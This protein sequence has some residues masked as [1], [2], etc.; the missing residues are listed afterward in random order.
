MPEGNG[1]DPDQLI[2]N[3]LEELAQFDLNELR[4]PD[5]ILASQSGQYKGVVPSV[6]SVPTGEDKELQWLLQSDFVSDEMALKAV[7]AITER[8]R[9]GVDTKPILLYL[10]AQ[11]AVNRKG[12]K[13]NR[14]AMVLEAMMHYK[15]TTTRQQGKGNDYQPD[16][17]SPI[18]Q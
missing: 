10:A 8:E 4:Q 13:T 5:A 17:K 2:E 15:V 1:H 18:N 12:P 14:T 7:N 9:Y 6:I 16:S 11:C 3:K